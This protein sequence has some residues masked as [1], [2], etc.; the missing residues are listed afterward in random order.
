M[1]TAVLDGTEV[2]FERRGSGR[3][4]LYCNGSG[5]TL[6]TVRPLLGTLA[7]RFDLLAF[8]YRGMGSSAPADGPYTM[9]DL[10]DDVTGLL[11]A[12]GWDRTALAG[13]S[14]GGMVAQEFAVTHPGR[15]DRLALLSTSPGGA[16]ASFPLD[17][18]AGLSA[19]QR[20]QRSLVLSDRRWTPQWLA[21]H[22]DQAALAAGVSHT[23]DDAETPSQ[24][25]GR[26]L[27]LQAR[28]NHDV[29]ERL[30]RIDCPTLVGNGRF[31]GIAPV[32]NGQA[33][34]DRVPGATMHVYDGGHL[35]L[36]QDPTAWP[37]LTAFLSG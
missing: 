35:F 10:A 8:D 7:A 5:A 27:Q 25:R 28:K 24:A 12:V 2:Y 22:P 16:F 33:I 15:V 17:R 26:L 13:L 19:G 37:D 9:A 21:A 6:D 11:D 23:P 14:C 31:D 1:P 30:H 20:A 32:A 36:V 4:L 29:L 3:R 34:V 18:L